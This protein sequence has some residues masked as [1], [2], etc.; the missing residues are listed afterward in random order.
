MRLV[1]F[2]DVHEMFMGCS[3]DGFGDVHG[4]FGDACEMSMGCLKNI[5]GGN[6]KSVATFYWLRRKEK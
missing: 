3:W 6:L 2:W 4:I 1:C 5:L